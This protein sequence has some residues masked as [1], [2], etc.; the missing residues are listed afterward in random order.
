[1]ATSGGI[2]LIILE[3]FTSNVRFDRDELRVS[4]CKS[5]LC[6]SSYTTT[7]NLLR[8][9]F[10]YSDLYYKTFPL[11]RP[12]QMYESRAEERLQK[13][14]MR[15]QQSQSLTVIPICFGASFV[16]KTVRSQRVSSAIV[17]T[18]KRR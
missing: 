9:L 8:I 5:V 2:K 16:A 3:I 13:V 1:M 15:K 18:R 14:H 17:N 10:K 11:K 7:L 12:F 4:L 6:V